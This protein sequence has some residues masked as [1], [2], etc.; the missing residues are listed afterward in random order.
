MTTDFT[1][2]TPLR[3]KVLIEDFG[4]KSKLIFYTYAVVDKW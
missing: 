1:I 3:Y 2:C 4:P